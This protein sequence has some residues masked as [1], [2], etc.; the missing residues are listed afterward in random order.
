MWKEREVE[1]GKEGR[2][3]GEVREKCVYVDTA[4]INL[5]FLSLFIC[6][7][8]S[9]TEIINDL[10]MEKIPASL[11]STNFSAERQFNKET[12]LQAVAFC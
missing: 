12:F 9:S 7:I 2:E 8:G 11:S 1:K 6:S 3:R 5:H 10:Q 4:R